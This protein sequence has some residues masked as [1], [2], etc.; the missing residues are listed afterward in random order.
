MLAIFG[1]VSMVDFGKQEYDRANKRLV[2]YINSS[3]ED[4]MVNVDYSLYFIKASL[5]LCSWPNV[6]QHYDFSS[7]SDSTSSASNS[8]YVVPADGVFEVSIDKRSADL[9]GVKE[10]GEYELSLCPMPGKKMGLTDVVDLYI[11]INRAALWLSNYRKSKFLED[12][13]Y[14]MK[15]IKNSEYRDRFRPILSKALFEM[16]AYIDSNGAIKLD[17]SFYLPN[18]TIIAYRVFSWRQG[19][20]KVSRLVNSLSSLKDPSSSIPYNNEQLWERALKFYS[21]QSAL[22]M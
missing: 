10:F 6:R 19:Y 13:A 3:G 8:D 2:E 12:V 22:A 21:G 4:I 15:N 5:E 18:H 7:S 1:V 14:I 20:E 17:E 11:N 9:N 16:N